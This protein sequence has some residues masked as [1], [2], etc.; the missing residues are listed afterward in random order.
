M[1]NYSHS[2]VVITR[3]EK[4]AISVRHEQWDEDTEQWDEVTGSYRRCNYPEIAI[5]YARE[6]T[7][8]MLVPQ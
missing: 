5:A 3:I 6:L 4:N 7:K 1:T 8:K 2:R